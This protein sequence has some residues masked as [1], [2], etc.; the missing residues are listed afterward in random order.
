[1]TG[2]GLVARRSLLRTAAGL[3][4]LAASGCASGAVG[5]GASDPEITYADLEAKMRGLF[6][7]RLTCVRTPESP[8]G[9]FYLPSSPA[10]RSLAE[11]RPGLRVRL[12]ITV[13]SPVIGPGAC[14]PIAGALVDVWQADGDGVYSNVAG[15]LQGADTRGQT[16]LRGHQM[17]DEAGYVEFDTVVPGWYVGP[18][19]GPGV[20]VYVPRTPHIHVKVYNESKVVTT[21]LYFPDTLLDRLY[22]EVAPYSGRRRL[23]SPGQ[24]E[25]LDRISNA[26][27]SV[28]AADASAPMAIEREGDGVFAAATVGVMTLTLHSAQPSLFR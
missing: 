25:P 3:P 21:Q 15:E 20:A 24:A 4:L 28:F 13:A 1:M 10:R 17:T 16:F 6:A 23:T 12:G 2:P 19:P 7:G 18:L 5:D 27:D 22:A 9:P 26:Q 14:A 8:D 11:G